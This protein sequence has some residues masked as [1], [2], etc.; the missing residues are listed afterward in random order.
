MRTT[1]SGLVLACLAAA[2]ASPLQA[3]VTTPAPLL[4][5]ISPA[6]AQ[7]GTTVEF[8]VAGTDLDGA[9]SLHF[10]IAGVECKPV[11]D[12]KQQP[13]A[14]KFKASIPATAPCGYCDVRVIAR[15]GI[16]N[17]RGLL[18]SSLPVVT[19]PATAIASDKA[20]KVAVNS[21]VSGVSVKQGAGYLSFDAKKGQRV[22][23]ICRPAWL[24]SRMD[25][26][27]SVSSADGKIL[28]RSKADGIVDF[29]APAD[30]AYTLK[31]GDLMYRGDAE[32]SYALTLTTGPVVEYAFDGGA[33]WTLYGRNLPKGADALKHYD[34]PL[35]RVQMP[36]EEAKKLLATNAIKPIRFG[37]ETEA[38]S[39]DVSKPVAL[40][41]PGVLTGWFPERGK[42]R[43]ITFE[44]KKGDAFW[45]ELNSASHGVSAD[46][47]MIV[48]KMAKDVPTFVAEANDRTALAT[49]EEFDAGW[50]D[51][52]Y[53][54]EAKEDGTYRI[55]LR[56]LFTSVPREPFELT[57]K[58]AGTDFDL[59]AIPT[60]LPKAKAATTVDVAAA[61]LWRGGSTAFKV[62]ALRRSGF[63]GPI[64]LSVDG[65]P[66]GVTFG[67][68]SF[69]EGQNVCYVSL[70]AAEDA[71]E[72]A[73]PIKLHGKTGGNAIGATVVFKVAAVAKEPVV[74]RFTD[75]VA[76]GVV[77]SD[78]PVSVEA[79]AQV[80]EAA[81]GGKLSIPL[82][83][84]RRADCTE[85]VKL[86]VL[87]LNDA[88]AETDVAA[89]GT[90][91]KL[92][93]DLAKLKVPAGDY[94]IVLQG[95]VKFKHKRLG[96][97]KAAAKDITFL[98]VSKPIKVHITPAAKK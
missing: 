86:A 97:A 5:S 31:V 10:S 15:Y 27:V 54:F 91:G 7:A 64:E 25:A 78:A 44:A 56:N 58:P 52:S 11:L 79:A 83:V 98:A 28:D 95:P 67:G 69:R 62:V 51:P 57:V 65:L 24:D 49:K 82:Q 80:F 92:D 46:P 63:T 77:A 1:I 14:N 68:G 38:P 53:R 45:I 36:A 21:V 4:T 13:V 71:K 22:L 29:V 66:P 72:W 12:A 34:H 35:Q 39:V 61:P 76:F 18:V 23:A 96:D 48:E 2:I 40:K 85:A 20:F 19:M 93:L 81:A 41:A 94:Q 47:F 30:G 42:A 55:K 90:T 75:E 9:S 8:T 59:V 84:K 89:K 3:Q 17:P 87:G 50:A 6:A 88:V 26:G 74:T 43:F 32:Y 60:A 16:S 33:T 70:S 73:G 37:A